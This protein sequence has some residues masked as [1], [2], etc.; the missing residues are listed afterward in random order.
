MD[1]LGGCLVNDRADVTPSVRGSRKLKVV[2]IALMGVHGY[3]VYSLPML[4]VTEFVR[5]NDFLLDIILQDI[6]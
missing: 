5:G 1:I 6:V 4:G 3:N 2:K